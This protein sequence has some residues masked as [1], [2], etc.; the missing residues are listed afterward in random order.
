P[1][2]KWSPR[3]GAVYSMNTKTVLRGGYGIF[4]AP[5]NAP[6]P[7]P[8]SNNYGQ[9]G[10]TLNTVV[11]QT[12]PLPTVSLSNPFPNGLVQ[13]KGSS[14]GAASGAGLPIG[15]VDQNGTAPRVQQFSVDLQRELSGNQA[16]LISYVGARGDDLGLGG[17][18]D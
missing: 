10:F 4:W 15:Y 6:T 11:P 12:A 2:V 14:L 3:V 7:S 16:I 17:S 9:V 8:S 5:W 18:N 1:K 13:P